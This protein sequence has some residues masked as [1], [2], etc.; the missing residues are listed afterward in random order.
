[1]RAEPVEVEMFLIT[2]QDAFI[3]MAEVWFG[4]PCDEDDLSC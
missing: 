4:T 1:M 3:A 2:C